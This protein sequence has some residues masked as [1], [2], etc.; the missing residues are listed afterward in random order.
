[1]SEP[2]AVERYDYPGGASI[3]GR[4][5]D[6]SGGPTMITLTIPVE[7]FPDGLTVSW[8]LSSDK[9]R[10]FRELAGALR[11]AVEAVEREAE[12]PGPTLEEIPPAPPLLPVRSAI[13]PPSPTMQVTL[14]AV[15][16]MPP[17][18]NPPLAPHPGPT[19]WVSMGQLLQD[20]ND[21]REV[22]WRYLLQGES[23]G[24]IFLS[25]PGFT[26]G[27]EPDN[28]LLGRFLHGRGVPHDRRTGQPIRVLPF[29]R[30]IITPGGVRDSE[31]G[32]LGVLL[33]ADAAT[34]ESESIAIVQGGYFVNEQSA[35]DF[36]FRL[37]GSGNPLRLA[38]T[39]DTWVIE[40]V[41]PFERP[42]GGDQR[43]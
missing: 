23:S 30:A 10:I 12:Q 16:P 3:E 38:G 4:I 13:D 8:T 31:N 19:R 18:N 28:E 41:H 27:S 43:E 5:G 26:P 15:M 7:G 32:E 17:P 34:W 2:G 1:M 20:Q 42:I 11:Q 33:Y 35:G 24:P 21:V 39:S 40:E 22:V 36:Q 29:S 37:R 9:R 25:A 6:L 14:P